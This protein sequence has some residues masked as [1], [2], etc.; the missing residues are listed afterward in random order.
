[1]KIIKWLAIKGLLIF[2]M[3]LIGI[4]M[5][6]QDPNFSQY[7]NTPLYYNPAFTG[8]TN[9]LNVRFSFRDQWPNLPVDFKSYYFSA[10]L[11]D[12]NLPGAGGLGLIINSNNEGIGFI[13]NFGCAISVGVRIPIADFLVSQVGIKGGVV[14]KSVN[15]DDFVFSDELD[16]RYGINVGTMTDFVNPDYSNR[17]YPDFGAG[18]L[19]QFTSVDSKVTFTTGFAIDHIFEPDESFLSTG[20]AKVPRKIVIQAEAVI[21]TNRSISANKNSRGWDD[22]V[23]LNPGIIYQSQGLSKSLAVGLNLLKYNLYLGAW[24]RS[25]VSK[26]ASN[27]MIFMAGYRYYFTEEMDI[28]FFYSYDLQIG[29]NLQETGGAHEISLILTFKDLQVFGGAPKRIVMKNGKKVRNPRE[30]C[31]MFN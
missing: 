27:A 26:H 31:E 2:C 8:I 1:M 28:K 29:G 3:A 23:K 24:F 9:G 22:P 11:G 5:R 17:I 6:G 4:A 25:T 13:H 16:E 21:A 7:F 15:W 18:G 30:A 19:L 12:R 10:D 14:Q 20:E